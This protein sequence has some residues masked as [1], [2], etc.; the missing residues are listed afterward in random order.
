MARPIDADLLAENIKSFAGLFTDEGF[1]IDYHAVL[2]AIQAAP[3]IYEAPAVRC[4]DCDEAYREAIKATIA[5]GKAEEILK[6]DKAQA[7]LK[8][9]A[10]KE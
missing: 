10:A 5:S 7:L 8:N 4:R 6:S 3:T 1:M 2:S 9:V